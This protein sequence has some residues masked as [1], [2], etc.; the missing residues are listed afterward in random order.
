MRQH[1]SLV[2]ITGG[3]A[4]PGRL[5]PAAGGWKLR[6]PSRQPPVRRTRSV[7]NAEWCG[8]PG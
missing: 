2:L 7:R 3:A 5:G 8:R 6:A 1:G 4:T